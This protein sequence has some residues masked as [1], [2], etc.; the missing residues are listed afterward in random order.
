MAKA[1]KKKASNK[2]SRN[3]RAA[4]RVQARSAPASE[5]G[6]LGPEELSCVVTER[7]SSGCTSLDAILGGPVR[8]T[9]DGQMLPVPF[10]GTLATQWGVP[11]GRIIET[12]GGYSTGKSSFVEN[13]AAQVQ[14]LGG[15]VFMI[16][17]EATVDPGR[18]ARMGVDVD[19]VRFR[20]V[21]IIPE[22]FDYIENVLLSRTGKEPPALISYDTIGGSSPSDD[23]P[24]SG[25]REVREGLRRVKTLIAQ[26][27]AILV[28]VNQIA[29]T[30]DKFEYEPATPFGAGVRFHAS[31]RIYFRGLKRF[32]EADAFGV[33]SGFYD[34]NTPIG[35]VPIVSAL[36]NKTFLPYRKCRA[37]LLFQ[38]KWHDDY[39]IWLYLQGRQ[40]SLSSRKPGKGE[41]DNLGDVWQIKMPEP[42]VCWWADWP[43]LMQQ[44]PEVRQWLR[45]ECFRLSLR[46]YNPV[47]AE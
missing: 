10:D 31:T 29:V 21:D 19:K 14:S 8:F 16:L 47:E 25:A 23:R 38:G 18:M 28:V 40:G 2:K 15:Q 6:V 22:G 41:P 35:I 37:P 42:V 43:A 30:F 20:E 7:M 45:E 36:K 1:K 11:V 46:G 32:S 13:L 39:G 24:G 9:E 4:A 34:A 26:K 5:L 17:A 12:I 3:T 27:R 44:R 33:K